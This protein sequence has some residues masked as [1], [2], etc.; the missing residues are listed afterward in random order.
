M[1]EST[2]KRTEMALWQYS[3]MILFV[4]VIEVVCLF[5]A[6]SPLCGGVFH[7]PGEVADHTQ[8][9]ET[10]TTHQTCPLM[11]NNIRETKYI[12]VTAT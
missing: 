3:N 6:G 1:Y 4:R 7:V 5:W 10:S 2:Q 12:Q 8:P 11:L 9:T